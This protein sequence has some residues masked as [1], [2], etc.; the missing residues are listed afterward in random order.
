PLRNYF[1]WEPHCFD[2]P[3]CWGL[4]STFESMD[5]IDKLS[6]KLHELSA[7]IE[8]LDYLLPHVVELLPS[9]VD[10]LTLMHSLAI[11]V[12]STFA[13]FV[14]QIEHLSHT[15]I[16]IGRSIDD[17][18]NDDLFYLPAEAF[19]NKDFQTGLRLFLSPDGRS[20]R[21]FVTHTDYPAT[22]E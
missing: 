22:P 6:E 3:F 16:I 19:D 4:R 21:F 14:Y 17:Y 18:K 20:A 13:A 7:N 8:R 9:V 1:Y 12:E 5:G 11:T 2:V 15:Q 10:T